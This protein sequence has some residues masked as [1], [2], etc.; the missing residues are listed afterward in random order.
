MAIKVADAK[1]S[2]WIWNAMNVSSHDYHEN[3]YELYM[4]CWFFL[5]DATVRVEDM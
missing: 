2:V 1:S 5:T 3:L 4:S